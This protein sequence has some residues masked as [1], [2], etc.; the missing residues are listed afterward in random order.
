MTVTSKAMI[1]RRVTL[2]EVAQFADKLTTITDELRNQILAPRPRK[3]APTFTS[4]EVASLCGI[5]RNRF[6]YLLSREGNS[7]PAGQTQGSRRSRIYSLVEARRWVQEVADIE[8]SPLLEEKPGQ[9][10]VLLASNFK[11]GSTK[12]TTACTLAQGLTLRGRRVLVIDV[13]PQASITELCGLYAEKDVREQDTVLSHLYEPSKSPLLD[14][15]QETYWDG[16][17]L[18]PAHTGLFSAEFHLPA[19]TA[20]SQGFKFWNLLRSG[21]EPLRERYDYIVMDSAPSLSY[22]TINAMMAADALIMPL[23]PES[24]D[25][26]S[27]VSFWSL[28]SDMSR[29]FLERGEEKSYDFISVLLS[30]VDYGPASSS[31][32]VRSWTQRAYQDWMH[33]IEIPASSVVSSSGLGLSTVFDMSKGDVPEKSLARAR[34]PMVEYCRWVDEQYTEHWRAAR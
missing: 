32:V 25:F 14:V 24:L 6:N 1:D 10:K 9:G 33:T 15:V 22:L 16:M 11:G 18:I 2:S 5:D 27:S 17:D 13:D 28:F 4:T 23:V 30:K 26:M 7:L 12:T 31:A 19:M 8:R 29:S 21:V 34:D 3:S 20:R